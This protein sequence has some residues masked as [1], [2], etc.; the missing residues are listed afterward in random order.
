MRTQ[1]HPMLPT[2]HRVDPETS[3]P[4]RHSVV[5]GPSPDDAGGGGAACRYG[6]ETRKTPSERH[7]KSPAVATLIGPVDERVLL[8][9]DNPSIRE[10]VTIG[11]ERAG[12]HVTSE[13]DGRQ[14]LMR[15]RN[16]RF[17]AVVLDLM[18]PSLDGVEI[19]REIRK[20]S[21][22]VIV[23]LTAKAETDEVVAGLEAGADDYVTK[24]FEVPELTARLK[25]VMRRAS[26][27]GSGDEPVVESTP[28]RSEQ[29]ATAR[30]WGLHRRSFVC[31]S[32]LPGTEG[33]SSLARSCSIECGGTTISAN[34]AS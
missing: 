28:G 32:S 34:R 20:D 6:P 2:G 27:V 29:L 5:V 22:V 15:F 11:L 9:E 25:A 18:L 31:F 14:G 10:V 7:C 16:A 33:R 19:C 23:I 13:G 4:T 1:L 24:P 30:I 17:D 12:L 8:V 26:S 21:G 3:A